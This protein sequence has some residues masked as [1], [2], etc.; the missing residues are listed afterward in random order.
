MSTSYHSFSFKALKTSYNEL[1]LVKFSLSRTAPT[2]VERRIHPDATGAQSSVMLT[3]AIKGW[4]ETDESRQDEII[5]TH[6][7]SY[8]FHKS[9]VK[10]SLLS[11]S[12]IFHGDLLE[13]SS[14]SENPGVLKIWKLV[15]YERNLFCKHFPCNGGKRARLIFTTRVRFSV[16]KVI[17][18]FEM[19]IRH[20][21]RRLCKF[22]S[23]PFSG[24]REKITSY[25]KKINKACSF[26]THFEVLNLY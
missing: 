16:Q 22:S 9:F 26:W 20:R 10:V 7:N 17:H 24:G 3:I 4:V 23:T 15:I 14:E 25:L 13:G 12:I 5:A 18:H 2:L 1:G 19:F 11:I 6:S 8:C 21:K